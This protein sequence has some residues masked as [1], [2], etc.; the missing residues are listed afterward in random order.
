M[1]APVPNATVLDS[2]A[3][4]KHLL[5][6][7]NIS[8][9]NPKHNILKNTQQS[10]IHDQLN[11]DDEPQFNAVALPASRKIKPPDNYR[12]LVRVNQCDKGV[13]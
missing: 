4:H 10:T 3:E 5:R 12:V 9:I 13:T 2:I 7:N 6:S 11:P 1:I 8:I